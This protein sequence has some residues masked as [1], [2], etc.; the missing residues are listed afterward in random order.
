MQAKTIDALLWQAIDAYHNECGVLADIAL[1]ISDIECA[2]EA[3]R[4][5]SRTYPKR[6][7]WSGLGGVLGASIKYTG[8]EETVYPTVTIYVPMDAVVRWMEECG[9]C[10]S[11]PQLNEQDESAAR[12]D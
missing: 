4:F 2:V 6:W 7:K 5:A 10:G 12:P 8:R 3:C 11:S 1:H 9:R